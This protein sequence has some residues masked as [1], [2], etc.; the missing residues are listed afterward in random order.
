MYSIN[1]FNRFFL[2]RRDESDHNQDN[3]KMYNELQKAVKNIENKAEIKSETAE[4]KTEVQE[5]KSEPNM[6]QMFSDGAQRIITPNQQM[7]LQVRL[8]VSTL[9]FVCFCYFI[10]GVVVLLMNALKIYHFLSFHRVDGRCARDKIASP[11]VYPR[12]C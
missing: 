3:N 1:L 8:Q 10:L 7:A 2:R 6:A 4:V 11:F 9:V 5:V 12:V